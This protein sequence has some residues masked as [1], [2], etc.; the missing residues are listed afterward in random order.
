[1]FCNGWSKIWYLSFKIK[2]FVK[3]RSPDRL[4]TFQ[5]TCTQASV[6]IQ[7]F[8]TEQF[9]KRGIYIVCVFPFLLGVQRPPVLCRGWAMETRSPER[10]PVWW[11][12]AYN[13]RPLD[14]MKAA[15]IW[16]G[17]DLGASLNRTT[18]HSPS[19]TCGS[20]VLWFWCKGL[21]FFLPSTILW[22]LFLFLI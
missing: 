11:K 1:M 14:T 2:V 6:A 21:F 7:Q 19:A 8:R 16:G 18:R 17:F 3:N 12:L 13:W 5:K 4:L 15:S 22:L 9:C 10:L 20:I